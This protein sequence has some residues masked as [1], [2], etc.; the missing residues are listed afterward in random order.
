MDRHRKWGG[1]S[2]HGSGNDNASP[3]D[4]A[5]AA[6][7]ARTFFS[8]SRQVP[9]Q[10]DNITVVQQGVEKF[11]ARPYDVLTAR[12]V[13]PLVKFIGMARHLASPQTVWL[14]PKGLSARS[15]LESLSEA[16]QG[17]WHIEDSITARGS[18]ILV[19]QGSTLA[20]LL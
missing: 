18:G 17:S 3:N 2:R 9:L 5:R 1:H 12:A 11:T 15:E 19:G 7:S 6:Q 14:L 20:K 10:L 4:I 8:D 16:C 13:A